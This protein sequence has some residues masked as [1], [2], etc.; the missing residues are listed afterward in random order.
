MR[1]LSLTPLWIKSLD[2]ITF[3]KSGDLPAPVFYV[4]DASEKK[5][6]IVFAID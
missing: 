5:M 2:T 3:G 1:I 4:W 6:T